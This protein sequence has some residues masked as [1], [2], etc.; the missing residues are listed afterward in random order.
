MSNQLPVITIITVV[1]NG[2]SSI[3][4]T[5]ESVLKYPYPHIEYIIIDGDSTDGTQEVIGPYKNALKYWVSEPD[6]GIYDAMNKGWNKASADSFIVFLGAGDYIISLPDMV[7]NAQQNIIYGKVDIGGRY[8]FNTNVNFRLKLINAVHHQALLIKKAI[9]P[10]SPFSLQFPVFADFDFNQRL[11][12]AGFCFTKDESFSS[13]AMAGGVSSPHNR[14]EMLQVVEN[15]YGKFYGLIARMY[16]L[17]Q[18]IK[19]LLTKF[20]P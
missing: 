14:K 6:K 2:A 19:N 4:D 16:Y 20:S 13:Y 15:N 12:K 5:I 10:L 8:V 18:N 3:K 9:Y 7:K 17:F 11:Y 1:Y